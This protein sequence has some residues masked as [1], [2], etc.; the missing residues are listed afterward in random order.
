MPKHPEDINKNGGRL[1]SGETIKKELHWQSQRKKNPIRQNPKKENMIFKSERQA[2]FSMIQWR[3]RKKK[4]CKN[5]R[6]YANIK[7]STE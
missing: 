6:T 2:L 5:V 4:T 3:E 7:I 1:T